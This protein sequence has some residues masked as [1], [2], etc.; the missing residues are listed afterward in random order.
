MDTSADESESDRRSRKRYRNTRDSNEASEDGGRLTFLNH[1]KIRK[2]TG[3]KIDGYR[4]SSSSGM[5]N[6]KKSKKSKKKKRETSEERQ[7]RKA[8]RKA[9]KEVAYY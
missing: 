3:F 7:I 1:M 8:E 4:K 5:K 6:A 2:L 9:E